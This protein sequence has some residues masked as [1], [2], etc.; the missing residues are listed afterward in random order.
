[1]AHADD[2]LRDPLN[3][4]DCMR[5]PGYRQ[6]ITIIFS[7]LP[8]LASI[9]PNL[10]G[11]S[12][13]TPSTGDRPPKDQQPDEPPTINYAVQVDKQSVI[14]TPDQGAGLALKAWKSVDGGPW[15]PAPK[16]QLAISI[17]PDT[18]DVLR[19]EA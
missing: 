19:Q 15:T 10:M 1:M 13:T 17:S 18:P 2:C 5:T 6:T 11:G 16:V 14:L 8:A 9:L 7:S 12:Q 3:A 4:A